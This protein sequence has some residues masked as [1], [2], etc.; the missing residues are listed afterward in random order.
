MKRSEYK[1]RI[2]GAF[3]LLGVLGSSSCV[4]VYVPLGG[5]SPSGSEI[6][7][8]ENVD[9]NL[10]LQRVTSGQSIVIDARTK[11]EFEE[12]HFP[13][14]INIPHDVPAIDT[15]LLGSNLERPVVVYCRSGKR[16]EALRSRLLNLG[17][18]NTI[19]GGGLKDLQK[20]K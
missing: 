6:T 17:Y 11:S 8:S 20:I 19:N 12:E 5:S 13:G 4:Q 18:R 2:A 15:N 10:V 14:A 16:A 7:A 9:T 3:I 1:N